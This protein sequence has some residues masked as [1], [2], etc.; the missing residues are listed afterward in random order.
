MGICSARVAVVSPMRAA[1]AIS[2]AMP[3]IM[4]G[5]GSAQQIAV[6]NLIMLHHLALRRHERRLLSGVR[7][8]IP[9]SIEAP[10][11]A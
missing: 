10:C 9:R 6:L 7:R 1:R 2:Y 4:E 5:N 3:V 8:L 11:N